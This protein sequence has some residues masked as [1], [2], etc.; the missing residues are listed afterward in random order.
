M[1]R[2]LRSYVILSPA[3]SLGRFFDPVG[4]KQS[5]TRPYP[6]ST[7]SAAGDRTFHTRDSNICI[8]LSKFCP[9]V[10]WHRE[11]CHFNADPLS[12]VAYVSP[13]DGRRTAR[14]RSNKSQRQNLPHRGRSS[15]G[16]QPP[17]GHPPISN[18]QHASTARAVEQD[19]G[20]PAKDLSQ[21]R[22]PGPEMLAITNSE[23]GEGLGD[24]EELRK[25]MEMVLAHKQTHQTSASASTESPTSLELAGGIALRR[26]LASGTNSSSD[27]IAAAPLS[28]DSARTIKGNLE[29]TPGAIRTPSYP[30][31]RMNLRL[32]RESSH[33]SAPSHKPFTLLSPTNTPSQVIE[34]TSA[35][36]DDP[37]SSGVSTPAAHHAGDDPNFPTPDLYDMILMLSA[38][39]GLEAWWANVT[40][41]MAEAYCAERASLAIPGD[42]TD[43]ENVPWGQK[44]TFNVY[45]ADSFGSSIHDSGVTSEPDSGAANRILEE[46][47][48][49]IGPLPT[50]RRPVLESRHSIAGVLPDPALK[51]ARQRPHGP[52]RA[53]SNIYGHDSDIAGPTPSPRALK[54]LLK[55]RSSFLSE[56]QSSGG[57]NKQGSSESAT[58]VVRA[59]VHR[60]LQALEVEPDSL[61]VRTG[62]PS[63]FGKRKP[64]VLTRAYADDSSNPDLSSQSHRRNTSLKGS[65]IRHVGAKSSERFDERER[66]RAGE[67]GR[68]TKSLR[69][70]DEYE[71]HEPSPWS[72]SPAPSPA[73]RPDPSESPFFIQTAGIDET[74]FE[75][76]PPA[77]DYA[78]T[79]N[80]SF[81]AI[82]A[83]SS[84]TLIHIPLIQ[85]VP[86]RGILSSSLR[87]PIAILS[88]LSPTNP[89][90]RNL[91]HSL[92]DLLPHL[93]S[94][95]SLA[96]QYS[97]LQSRLTG[98][99]SGHRGTKV[100]NWNWWPS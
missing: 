25:R 61:M 70:Y 98:P 35:A 23:T 44:A 20:E 66:G 54:Q 39:P 72:Q 33:R 52:V 88:F 27:T 75:P 55:A 91:R 65:A 48:T 2:L 37:A 58:S 24:V 62:I 32:N 63:M 29:M 96:Q 73:A 11:S 100:P 86:S 13:G 93:A 95:Y 36:T 47:D 57:R 84:K 81:A 17:L 16:S 1:Q 76:N 4:S 87:F 83:D 56:S 42:M 9:A 14:M 40:Q 19:L 30:F 74:A 85:P 15:Q 94:S 6:P 41:I 77:F 97:N 69:T 90:P 59:I 3:E 92:N 67:A 53:K 43:L 28:T 34:G 79:A 10:R 51:G 82:G 60:T 26:S 80:H 45:G 99:L 21:A 7:S 49:A 31:P 5:R 89:Y 8:V 71:Q 22:E 12:I 78:A 18:E 50:T 68:G 38:E 46:P 64:V